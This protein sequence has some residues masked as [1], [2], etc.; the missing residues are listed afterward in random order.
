[1]KQIVIISGKGGTGKT[2]VTASI[3][4]LLKNNNLAII[5]A[6]VDASNLY[7][8]LK[9]SI[10]KEFDFYGGLIAYIDK[11][12]C[13][14]CGKCISVCR[15]GAIDSEYNISNLCE[16]CKFCYNV[17]D[18][19]AIEMKNRFSGKW[20]VSNT[21]YG[22]MFHARLEPG[23]ENS[24]KLVSKIKEAAKEYS[25]DQKI[26]YIIIDGPP[27][28]G[29]PVMASISGTDIAV[30]VTEPTLSGISDME[31]A[32]NVL[33]T[34]GVKFFVVINKFDI[35]HENSQKIENI[36]R[37]KGI[38]VICKI[39][40]DENVEKAIALTKPFAESFPDSPASISLKKIL[41]K[42]LEKLA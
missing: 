25:L 30:V 20:F 24:G 16:G 42:I 33:F 19:K 2:S 14:K 10:E 5:D 23:E 7:I 29:C 38:E 39:P 6:D 8:L 27:G 40:F 34:L 37:E 28:I 4:S 1:M 13:V 15:F 36:C 9:P 35:N 41:E 31:R 32:S 21:S 3:V 26:D 11:S 18:F 17:C 12:K 22:K